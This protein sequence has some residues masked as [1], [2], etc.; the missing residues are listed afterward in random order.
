MSYCRFQNTLSDLIDCEENFDNIKSE[1]EARAALRIIKI[2]ERIAGEFEGMSD[3]EIKE[4]LNS[5]VEAD[6]DN[7]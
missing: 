1:D 3:D 4:Q 6:E 7:E 5:S 2:A